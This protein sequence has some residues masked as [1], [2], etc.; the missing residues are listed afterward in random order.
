VE[1]EL[2]AAGPFANPE[3]GQVRFARLL[4]LARHSVEKATKH[5][6]A[7]AAAIDAATFLKTFSNVIGAAMH[8]FPPAA[9]AWSGICAIIPVCLE[10]RS[11]TIAPC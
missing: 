2:A 8:P 6:N 5:E 10:P 1:L 7:K 11:P 4:L 3:N 9:V